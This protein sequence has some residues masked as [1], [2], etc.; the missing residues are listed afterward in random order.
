MQR[1]DRRVSLLRSK[2][3][4]GAQTREEGVGLIQ[5]YGKYNARQGIT[6][7]YREINRARSLL[8]KPLL[9]CQT[10]HIPHLPIC[11]SLLLPLPLSRFVLTLDACWSSEG[12]CHVAH[13]ILYVVSYRAPRS[14]R[15]SD[16]VQPPFQL[17]DKSRWDVDSSVP[18]VAKHITSV[19][20]S[21]LVFAV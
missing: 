9:W 4:R 12:I 19:L 3:T 1:L 13:S 7:P 14:R 15:R 20:A 18:H 11:Q 5:L 2:S 21:V 6:R 10:R 16:R 17:R 8:Y